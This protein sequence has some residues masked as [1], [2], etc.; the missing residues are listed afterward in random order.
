MPMQPDKFFTAEQIYRLTALMARLPEA[1]D[2]NRE[3]A[4]EEQAEV[5]QLIAAELKGTEERAKAILA[6]RNK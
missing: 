1:R 5:E 2:H 3:L 4:P 6:A